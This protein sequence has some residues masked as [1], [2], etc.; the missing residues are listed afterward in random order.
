M[1]NEL[2]DFVRHSREAFDDGPPPEAVWERISQ[3]GMPRKKLF[4]MFTGRQ[5]AAVLVL[6]IN[7]ALVAYLIRERGSDS[8]AVNPSAQVQAAAPDTS[9]ERQLH[10]I[11]TTVAVQQARLEE[12]KRTEPRLYSDFSASLA[13]LNSY[14]VSLQKEIKQNPNKEQ[15]F[16]AMIQNLRLQQE[17]LNQQLIIFKNLKKPK[18][19]KYS[20]SL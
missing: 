19:E 15:L 4:R 11:S 8:A 20:K 16:E 14:Y 5:A 17:L 18:N 2:E 6:L 3:S 1:K 9:Y 12:V 13:Q 10:E 7:A